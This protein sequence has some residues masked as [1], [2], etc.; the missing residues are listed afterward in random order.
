MDKGAGL[1]A[2]G[3]LRDRDAAPRRLRP[4]AAPAAVDPRQRHGGADPR[5]YQ[6]GIR[7][8]RARASCSGCSPTGASPPRQ[9]E[10]VLDSFLGF[11]DAL[12]VPHKRAA[13]GHSAAAPTRCAYAE[14]LIPDA[15]PTLVISACS[16]HRARNWLPER[17]AAVADHAVH[18][19]G[20]RVILCGGPNQL[21]RDMAQ[22]IAKHATVPLIDQVGKR[23][24]AA[25]A[26]AAARATVLRDARLRPGAHGD[27]G[28]HARSSACTP[29]PT[30]S[31][32]G[33]IFRAAGA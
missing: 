26:R 31:A 6:A 21:E 12:G 10:H 23:H 9:R 16:S 13:L 22:A 14:Q 20:M 11:A 29:P 1:S 7:Q 15:Q 25:A 28:R 3:R 17:Y 27:H 30:P 19:H 8:G 32:A 5:A 2:F 18:K 24:A 33:R 4:A